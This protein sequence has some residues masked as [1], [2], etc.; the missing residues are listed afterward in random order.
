[1]PRRSRSAPD[2]KRITLAFVEVFVG[3]GPFHLEVR[4]YVGC[5]L[6]SQT[7]A[8]G[9]ALRREAQKLASTFGF[10]Q[11]RE[12]RVASTSVGVT[13]ICEIDDRGTNKYD[14]IVRFAR[15]QGWKISRK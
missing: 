14:A 10:A 1:M 5:H 3:F 2:K 4:S 9:E 12:A 7:L 6:A 11:P 15:S 8:L 13:L